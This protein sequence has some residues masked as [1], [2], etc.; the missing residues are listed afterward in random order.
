MVQ[1]VIKAQ[2]KISKSIE[3][4]LNLKKMKFLLA[5]NLK[6]SY[7]TLNNLYLNHHILIT[8]TLNCLHLP[9][10]SFSSKKAKKLSFLRAFSAES[11]NTS[12]GFLIY[13]S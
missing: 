13:L 10:N 3:L 12:S 4:E 5:N 8:C 6:L 1:V 11:S 9:F 2:T 7:K